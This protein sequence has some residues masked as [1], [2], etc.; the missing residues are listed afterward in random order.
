ME[1]RS[2]EC[3]GLTDNLRMSRDVIEM[4]GRQLRHLQGSYVYWLMLRDRHDYIGMKTGGRSRPFERGH[5]AIGAHEIHDADTLYIFPVPNAKAA[6]WTEA[7]LI[8]CFGP[9]L[10]QVRP[11]RGEPPE[12][13]E[14]AVRACLPEPEP[15]LEDEDYAY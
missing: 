15:E 11:H 4:T 9:D 3:A 12:G 6:R 8:E 2:I 10:N 7:V 1:T 13:F 5:H 14:E